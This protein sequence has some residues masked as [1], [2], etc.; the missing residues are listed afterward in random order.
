M[1]YFDEELFKKNGASLISAC[2][3]Q[4]SGIKYEVSFELDNNGLNNLQTALRSLET[5][6]DMTQ[7]KT[8]LTTMHGVNNSPGNTIEAK[9]DNY[10]NK[11]ITKV[12]NPESKTTNPYYLARYQFKH[13]QDNG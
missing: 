10:L 1:P 3:D 12:A 13:R 2:S 7:L 8:E 6:D 9:I 4:Y 5:K 11:K